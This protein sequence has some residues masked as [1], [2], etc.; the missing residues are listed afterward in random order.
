M[1]TQVKTRQPSV[2]RGFILAAISL[3]LTIASISLVTFAL[4]IRTED[5]N[6]SKVQAGE[7]DIELYIQTIVGTEINNDANEDSYGKLINMTPIN[8]VTGQAPNGLLLNTLTDSVFDV[9][10]AVPTQK[11]TATFMIKNKGTIAATFEIQIT[12]LVL[13]AENLTHDRI[14][15]DAASEALSE[16]I[17]ITMTYVDDNGTP[18]K[19]ENDVV[20]AKEFILSTAEG[21]PIP[22]LI[23]P[24]VKLG[25]DIYFTISWEFL[26]DRNN[27]AENGY[28]FVNN[29][30][31]KGA[32][33][34]D[35]T[36]IAT[37]DTQ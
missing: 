2:M 18:M 23:I 29:E 11:Q 4:F 7:L 17:L 6:T 28:T 3:I 36:V 1:E 32:V 33:Q 20:I 27:N 12:D 30:A 22:S 10:E 5:H 34:F 35:L 37:Q 31:Q 15:V 9:V 25:E 13:N 16:Q 19:D 24:T 8:Y 26:D 21:T 14:D